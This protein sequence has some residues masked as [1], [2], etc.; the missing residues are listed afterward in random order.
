[1]DG[2]I[3]YSQRGAE[4]YLDLGLPAE[5]VF[6][7]HNAA[8][9]PPKG[10][11][12]DRPDTI[13]RAVVLFV[14]RLQIRKRLEMLFAACSSLPIETRPELIVVGDGPAK[15]HYQTQAQY[16]YPQTQFDGAK[17]GEELVPYFAKADL[18]VLPGTGGLAVQQAMSHGLPVVVAQ[19]DGTQEDLVRSENGWMIPPDDQDKL[20][21][22]LAEALA[23]I[24][25]L[26]KMGAASYRITA[27]EINLV[28]MATSFIQAVNAVSRIG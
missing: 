5:R 6:V 4:Q 9:M 27:E 20:N 21:A 23:D 17:H 22:V 19:G 11:P 15:D 7:A 1:L 10:P 18:F 24:P 28:Q 2:V 8:V 13:E 14:G 12:P 25:R 26:R 16:L 3:A